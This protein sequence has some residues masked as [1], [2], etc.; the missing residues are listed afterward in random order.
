MIVP[1]YWAEAREQVRRK[2][3]QVT[4]RRFGWSDESRQAAQ[5]HAEQ[6]TQEA[7]DAI[8]AGREDV[9]RRELRS[10]YG[11][12][13]VPIREQ[14]VERHDDVI[15]TRN[16]YGALCL[17]TPDVLFADMD[18]ELR[19]SGWVLPFAASVAALLVGFVA[20]R[21]LGGA[22]M[23]GLAAAVVV[24]VAANRLVLLRRRRRFDRDGGAERRAMARVEAFVS[25][26]PE[27]HLRLY[28]TPA[29]LRVLAMHQAFEPRDEA[30]GRLFAALRADPLYSTMC[31]VQHC[32]RAR[33][34]AK[35]WRIGMGRR[36]RPPVAAWSPEQAHLPERLAWIA[37]YERKAAGF[38]ACR[39]IGTLGDDSRI[40]PKARR[41]QELHDA[42]TRAGEPL[43]LA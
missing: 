2:G 13:G 25:Q 9:P 33:L 14:I 32:F 39:Y 18:F 17:N 30:V 4:V 24:L 28:R 5:A 42:M 1:E 23:W 12:H 6:R 41:V 19:P 16:S 29:G 15:V 37:D 22:V 8:L 7:L 20:G 26:H 10:N 27:W 3:R 31:Q 35:P 36:I 21:V 40:D 43:P 38:A 11:T 34:T